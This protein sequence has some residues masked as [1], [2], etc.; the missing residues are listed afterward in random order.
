MGVYEGYQMLKKFNGYIVCE[1]LGEK[2]HPILMVDTTKNLFIK[3]N[4]YRNL[5]L[6]ESY[7]K[8]IKSII[9]EFLHLSKEYLPLLRIR[10]EELKHLRGIE[11]IL[12]EET[13]IIYENQPILIKHIKKI[14]MNAPIKS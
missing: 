6:E 2:D 14:I 8:Q 12:N 13:E 1:D 9:H 5:K 3:V 7:E 10:P 4:I 11:K